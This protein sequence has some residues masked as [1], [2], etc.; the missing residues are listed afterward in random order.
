MGKRSSWRLFCFKAPVSVFLLQMIA[1]SIVVFLL[2]VGCSPNRLAAPGQ[3]HPV[4]G[5][6]KIGA[7]GKSFLQGAADS[8]AS[9]DEKPVMTSSF[10]YD[11]WIDTVEVTQQEYAA[12][13][14]MRPV[15]DTSGYGVGNDYPV[16]RVSWFDAILFCNQRSKK[17]NLDTVYSYFGSPLE[18]NGSVYDLAGVQIHYDRDGYRLPTESEWEY[19]AREGTSVIPFPGISDSTEADQYA[20]YFANSLGSTHPVATREKNSFGLYDMA[21]NVY[22][23]TADWRGPYSVSSITNSIGA[24]QP[25]SGNERVVKG[26][27]FEHGFLNLR[28]SR[29]SST[30]GTPQSTTTEYIGFRCARGTIARTSFITADTASVGTNPVSIVVTSIQSMLPASL[31]KVVFVNV[32]KDVRTLC[33]VDFARSFPVVS[34]YRDYKTVFA[35]VISP[36]GKF[37]AFCTSSVGFSG[38][39][40]VYLRSLDSLGSPLVKIPTDSAYDPRFWVDPVSL[41]TFLIYTNSSIDNSSL[42]WTSS[43]TDMIKISGGRPVGAPT[44]LVANGS[45]HDGRS[46][47]GQYIVTGYTRLLM[48]DLKT[49]IDAFL[50][51]YPNNGKDAN[52]STQVCNVSMSPDSSSNGTCLFL[53]FGCPSTSTL[54]GERYGV[55]EYLFTARFSGEVTSW[56]KCPAGEVAWDFPEWSNVAPLAIACGTNGADEAHAIYLIDL[57]NNTTLKILEGTDLEYPCLWVN[58]SIYFSEAKLDLDSLGN[59]NSPSISYTQPFFAARMLAFWQEYKHMR[60]VFTGS[61]QSAFSVDPHR[62]TVPGVYNMAIPGGDYPVE[63]AMITGYL[64]N[65][66]DS[67][68]LVGMDLIPG[69]L[70]RPN[71]VFMADWDNGIMSS[72]GFNYDKNHQF[73]SQG[74]PVSFLNLMDQIPFPTIPNLDTLGLYRNACNGW[75]GQTPDHGAYPDYTTDDSVYKAN[76]ALVKTFARTLAKRGIHFLLYLTP[77]SP[78]FENF[79]EFENGGPS[80]QTAAMIFNDLIA[81][82]DSIPGYFHFYDADKFGNHDYTDADAYD[83]NHLCTDGAQKFSARLDSVVKTILK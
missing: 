69:L 43:Q 50:F 8:N 38:A 28:F 26:G 80:L 10:S 24:A 70:F 20:W 71:I 48:R 56:R 25:N 9:G 77:L 53:D 18:Q 14:G 35:P 51:T 81:L 4:P 47:N 74:L 62:F 36:N 82:Q 72:K 22:E 37:V 21:G 63:T 55:H 23:W 65:Y 76:L 5:M 6:N 64:L 79:G 58:P 34:E 78:Y 41:D 40:T 75:G 17:E 44:V 57:Q 32:N 29:R 59:Y 46:A 3:L 54:T 11:Y 12:C 27:S 19:A 13:T 45:F 30:Y 31:A 52:G 16:Y 67:L 73:W 1:C 68:Q 2:S 33:A 39:A 7:A 60:I 83:A 15:K 49:G 66:C 42:S 61:S